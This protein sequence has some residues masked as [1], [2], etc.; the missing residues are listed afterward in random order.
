MIHLYFQREYVNN[1]AIRMKKEYHKRVSPIVL[2]GGRSRV[3]HSIAIKPPIARMAS[4][5][6]A[7]ATVLRSFLNVAQVAAIAA[8]NTTMPAQKGKISHPIII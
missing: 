2:I 5:I 6:V 8:I 1:P 4:D 3:A 7:I